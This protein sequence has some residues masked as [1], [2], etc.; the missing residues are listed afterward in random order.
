MCGVQLGILG[1]SARL[2]RH[3]ARAE[4]A[5]PPGAVGAVCT[6]WSAPRNDVYAMHR[7]GRASSPHKLRIGRYKGYTE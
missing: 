6:L 5:C 2:W 7:I 3:P 1:L 4:C